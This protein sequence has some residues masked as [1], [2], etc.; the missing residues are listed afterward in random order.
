MEHEG[1]LVAVE[2][3]RERVRAGCG[4]QVLAAAAAVCDVGLVPHG[5]AAA[6]QQPRAP[7]NRGAAHDQAAGPRLRLP[8]RLPRPAPGVI[9]PPPPPSGRP[10]HDTGT[11]APLPLF[12]PTPEQARTNTRTLA[13]ARARTHTHTHTSCLP[14]SVRP[15]GQAFVQRAASMHAP[16]VRPD[17]LSFDHLHLNSHQ[18]KA[19]F[20]LVYVMRSATVFTDSI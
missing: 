8:R 19:I 9:C 6:H 12:P 5:G 7:R 10:A 16:A 1:C 18:A 2:P 4:A 11:Q 14:C 20:Q 15:L 3:P 13:C 17:R